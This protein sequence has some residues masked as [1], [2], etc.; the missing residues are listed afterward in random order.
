MRLSSGSGPPQETTKTGAREQHAQTRTL[1]DTPSQEEDAQAHHQVLRTSGE[2]ESPPLPSSRSANKRRCINLLRRLHE[3]NGEVTI[4]TCTDEEVHRLRAAKSKDVWW[5]T[6]QL[7][8]KPKAILRQLDKQLPNEKSR[9]VSEP[10]IL[11]H[12]I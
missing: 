6:R 7:R 1:D 11:P 5:V 10:F 3:N 8:L 4:T 12:Q 9:A 2:S